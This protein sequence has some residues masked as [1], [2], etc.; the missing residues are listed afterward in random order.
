MVR[1]FSG[2]KRAVMLTLLVTVLFILM[3]SE[4]VTYIV[5]SIE[6]NTLLGVASGV[7]NS[8]GVAAS[9]S[10]GTTAFL[11]SSLSSAVSTLIGIEA[12]PSVRRTIFVNNTQYMLTSLMMNGT[13][14]GRN[15]SSQ[16]GSS[17]IANY[18]N[19]VKETFNTQGISYSMTSGNLT[20]YQTSPSLINATYTALLVANSSG[21][22]FTYPIR[23]TTSVQL[24]GTAD[25]VLDQQASLIPVAIQQQYPQAARIGGTAV[26][27]SNSPFMFAAGPVIEEPGAPSCTGVPSRF[28]SSGYILMVQNAQNIGQNVCGMSGLIANVIS[29]TTPNVPYLVYSNA[30]GAGNVF[31]LVQNGTYI[32]LDGPTLSLYNTTAVQTAINN[33]YYYTSPY[34]APYLTY[35]QDG[36]LNGRGGDG[37]A[38]FSSLNTQVG[39]FTGTSYIDA[40]GTGSAANMINTNSLTVAQ[41]VYPISLS[42]G[43]NCFDSAAAYTYVG[44]VFIIRPG[45][46]G[47]PGMQVA[48]W[49]NGWH[50]LG[51]TLPTMQLDTWNFVAMTF[52]GSYL[53]GYLNGVSSEIGV[54][55]TLSPQ[56]GTVMIGGM[57]QPGSSAEDLNGLIADTQI[58]NASLTA[59]QINQLYGEG[60]DGTPVMPANLVAWYPLNNNYND[61]GPNEYNG[62]ATNVQFR[63]LPGYYG[64]PLYPHSLSSFNT[65]ILAGVQNC[66]SPT[67]CQNNML[68]HVYMQNLP[69]T[70]TAS[71]APVNESATFGLGG[72][73]APRALAFD[74]NG[75]YVITT[76]DLSCTGCVLWMSQGGSS[77]FFIASIWIYPYSGN[78]V[79]LDALSSTT[80]NSG[81][82]N[83]L[84]ELVNGNLEVRWPTT[85]CLNLGA[86]PI[87]QWTN[88]EFGLD[89]SHNL[90]TFVN[91]VM[92]VG[93]ISSGSGGQSPFFFAF[94]NPDSKNCGSGVAYSGLMAQ[95]QVVPAYMTN[96]SANA[97]Q[98]YLNNSVPNY[99]TNVLIPFDTWQNG[100]INTTREIG[101]T[102]DPSFLMGST[103][104]CTPSNVISGACGVQYVP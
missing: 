69:L 39:W 55:G 43:N 61:Y 58:Y 97:M 1:L 64:D 2:N 52:D 15:F 36:Y 27:G 29:S 4:V 76:N 10:A 45:N 33:N 101:S 25:L 16:I 57:G 53:K 65:S 91:G 14:Y 11:H 60:L 70:V 38:S 22:M 44:N 71:G 8:G 104:P 28:E 9:V 77:P 42:G 50:F 84:I 63:Q 47:S 3:L 12:N 86:V 6:Y 74:G 72:A 35:A 95:F 89:S 24:N 85:A 59:A 80:P 46:C 103:Y 48:V 40:S 68:S 20:V 73:L 78:G 100:Q 81:A 87:D 56:G 93:G 75:G 31:S 21:G 30:P 54:S 18:S 62:V 49:V 13:L 66:N 23:A 94:G 67:M 51:A 92:K 37:I 5:V 82:H 26:A 102:P 98:L 88:V 32:L 96:P 83:S 79:I 99:P 34:T 19:V 90:D 7:S 17:T 41:W